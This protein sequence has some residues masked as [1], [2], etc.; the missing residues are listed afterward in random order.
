MDIYPPATNALRHISIC[1]FFGFFLCVVSPFFFLD[2]RFA[3][4]LCMVYF[5]WHSYSS[6]GTQITKYPH[7]QFKT[8]NFF[9]CDCAFLS[10]IFGGTAIGHLVHESTNTLTIRWRRRMNFFFFRDSRLCILQLHFCVADAHHNS[11]ERKKGTLHNTQL[12]NTTTKSKGTMEMRHTSAS[13]NAESSAW[14]I[15]KCKN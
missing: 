8:N 3:W 5:W 6:F 1:P 13:K 12:K 7:D 4:C 2:S 9:S 11:E 14:K 15:A 10:N